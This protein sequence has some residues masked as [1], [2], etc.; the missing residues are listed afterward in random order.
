MNIFSFDVSPGADVSE[1][2]IVSK[3]AYCK[4]RIFSSP[5]LSKVL[6]NKL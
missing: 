2:C 3:K 4:N 1:R 5:V 6:V